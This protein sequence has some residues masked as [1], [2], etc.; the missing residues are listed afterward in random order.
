MTDEQDGRAPY[1]VISWAAIEAAARTLDP[2]AFTGEGYGPEAAAQSR[3]SALGS[4]EAAIRA[5]VGAGLFVGDAAWRL[6]KWIAERE[7]AD[8]PDGGFA[9]GYLDALHDVSRQLDEIAARP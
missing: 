3:E 2:N 8:L 7:G 1:P 9:D 4:A 6:R 5:A